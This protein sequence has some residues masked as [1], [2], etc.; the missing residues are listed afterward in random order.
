M[1]CNSLACSN[2]G[3]ITLLR[4]AAAGTPAETERCW[5]GVCVGVLQLGGEEAADPRAAP[6]RQKKKK[7]IVPVQ[8]G[9]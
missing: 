1:A 3:L 5:Y 8:R 7:N 4:L 2:S 9:H 6:V